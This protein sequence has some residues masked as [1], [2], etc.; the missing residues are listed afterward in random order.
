MVVVQIIKA[1][2]LEVKCFGL[3]MA[4]TYYRNSPRADHKKLY[5]VSIKIIMSKICFKI[6]TKI[7][8]EIFV[9]TKHNLQNY[10]KSNFYTI[11]DINLFCNF[12]IYRYFS[13]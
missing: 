3:P 2:N 7:S 4:R 13:V 9:H 6:K 1:F 12:I 5:K 11:L 10:I 8:S